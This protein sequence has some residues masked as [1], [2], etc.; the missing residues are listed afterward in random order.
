MLHHLDPST[1]PMLIA[2]VH[3][4]LEPGGTVHL[5]DFAHSPREHVRPGA[6]WLQTQA[7][8]PAMAVTFTLSYLRSA[9]AAIVWSR[10]RHARSFEF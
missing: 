1:Q 3:R 5:L 9:G 7:D 6:T 10:S 8:Q 2:E 4:V